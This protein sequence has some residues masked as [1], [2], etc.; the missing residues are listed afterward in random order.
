[1][2]SLKVRCPNVK[3]RVK[4]LIPQQLHGHRV[5]CAGCGEPFVVP[6]ILPAS[7]RMAR[8]AGNTQTQGRKKAS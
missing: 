2:L 3:C 1:M 7:L 6:P 4:L 5:R 8:G